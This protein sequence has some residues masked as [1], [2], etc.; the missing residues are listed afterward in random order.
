[1]KTKSSPTSVEFLNTCVFFYYEIFEMRQVTL[2]STIPTVTIAFLMG[3]PPS[4]QDNFA[5]GYEPDVSHLILW[6]FLIVSKS[7]G[8]TILTFVGFTKKE[9]TLKHN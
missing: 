4:N 8:V 9:I 5:G 7:L 6:D 3:F 1:M 2:I